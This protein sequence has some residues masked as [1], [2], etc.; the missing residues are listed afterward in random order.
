MRASTPPDRC[1]LEREEAWLGIPTRAW[2]APAAVRSPSASDPIT[3]ENAAPPSPEPPPPPHPRPPLS[4]RVKPHAPVVPAGG[5]NG[6]APPAHRLHSSSSSSARSPGVIESVTQAIGSNRRSLSSLGSAEMSQNSPTSASST[7]MGVGGRLGVVPVPPSPGSTGSTG[8]SGAPPQHHG[9][10]GLGAVTHGPESTKGGQGSRLLPGSSGP[11]PTRHAAPPL[12]PGKRGSGAKAEMEI[13]SGGSGS[14]GSSSAPLHPDANGVPLPQITAAPPR[15]LTGHS[16]SSSSPVVPVGGSR[17]RSGPPE[18][19]LTAEAPTLPRSLPGPEDGGAHSLFPSTHVNALRSPSTGLIP[20]SPP[21][22]LPRHRQQT[23][24]DQQESR[25]ANDASSEE[26]AGAAGSGPLGKDG[27]VP[28]TGLPSPQ[29]PSQLATTADPAPLERHHRPRR[30]KEEAETTVD[31]T[32]NIDGQKPEERLASTTAATACLPP[33]PPASASLKGAEKDLRPHSSHTEIPHRNTPTSTTDHDTSAAAAAVASRGV[34][35]GPPDLD[36]DASTAGSRRHHRRHHRHH[37]HHHHHHES[38]S[39]SQDTRSTHDHDAGLPP[40]P[41]PAGEAGRERK[42]R[43]GSPSS[44]HV[45]RHHHHH[46]S[47]RNREESVAEEREHSRRH[48]QRGKPE[49]ESLRTGPAQSSETRDTTDERAKRGE[50]KLK[51]SKS[52]RNEGVYRLGRLCRNLF[53][54]R[55][56]CAMNCFHRIHR[57]DRIWTCHGCWHMFHLGCV[58]RWG[59]ESEEKGVLR[60][61]Q[62][63]AP[64]VYPEAYKCFCG[65]VVNPP[66]VEATNPRSSLPQ[67]APAA[68]AEEEEEKKRG[69]EALERGV[70]R[71]DRDKVGHRGSSPPPHPPTKGSS[72]PVRDASSGFFEPPRGCKIRSSHPRSGVTAI[73]SAVRPCSTY[74]SSSSSATRKAP[75]SHSPTDGGAA[76]SNAETPRIIPHPPPPPPP[77]PMAPHCCTGICERTCG[78]CPHPCQLPCHPGP[79]PTCMIDAIDHHITCACG[80][81]STAS[82]PLLSLPL[83]CGTAPPKCEEPCHLPRPCGHDTHRIKPHT[84]HFGACPPLVVQQLRRRYMQR[85]RSLKELGS[86][87]KEL[88]V[89]NSPPQDVVWMLA[90]LINNILQ[91]RE[92]VETWREIVQYMRQK[93]FMTKILTFRP[94]KQKM[95][96]MDLFTFLERLMVKGLCEKMKVVCVPAYALG[97]WALA[98]MDYMEG[99]LALQEMLK[100][101]AREDDDHTSEDDDTLLELMLGMMFGPHQG[102]VGARGMRRRD[103]PASGGSSTENGAVADE[104]QDHHR[105]NNNNGAGDTL[106]DGEG[107]SRERAASRGGAPAN[108]LGTAA[109]TARG[110]D[111]LLAAAAEAALEG[112]EEDVDLLLLLGGAERASTPPHYRKKPPS[113]RMKATNRKPRDEMILWICIF[114]PPPPPSPSLRRECVFPLLWM[115]FQIIVLYYILFSVSMPLMTRNGNGEEPK[116]PS[117]SPLQIRTT[118]TTKNT[119]RIVA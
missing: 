39:R 46:S 51:G 1:S 2:A 35:A 111:T 20:A 29:R 19:S 114:S 9:V 6:G 50:E 58:Q 61:P 95:A 62:C 94:L 72:A 49:A 63:R 67:P 31:A 30:R 104:E 64:H 25:A 57:K 40:P 14:G 13:S 52:P 90:Y 108:D 102:R 66:L 3:E 79:C 41:A 97:R 7:G 107:V 37:H 42:K 115:M 101:A 87:W 10:A 76:A 71:D 119:H 16:T 34:E 78:N 113:D 60:C 27:D 68:A 12:Q 75:P 96:R 77:Q 85:R 48:Q 82:N 86:R 83:P 38:C 4:H 55:Y 54:E 106:V 22:R 93:G 103:R 117:P 84:C 105:N 88:L 89:Y 100:E 47:S 116:A 18:R 92:K 43:S 17:R 32:R 99:S 91:E 44:D 28:T 33:R 15:G 69:A 98:V 45:R 56:P 81:T 5:S 23:P 74:S 8:S 11:S 112:R 53:Q 70:K 36:S 109:T 65:K 118:T 26:G 73:T 21:G 80:K 59:Q 110:V 24:V